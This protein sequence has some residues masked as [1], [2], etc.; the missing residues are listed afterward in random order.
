MKVK[1]IYDVLKLTRGHR[2]SV[3]YGADVLFGKLCKAVCIVQKH[4]AAVHNPLRS[5]VFER[6][7]K[8]LRCKNYHINVFVVIIDAAPFPSAAES[9]LDK[10]NADIAKP[11]R[12]F[13]AEPLFSIARG[14]YQVRVLKLVSGDGAS[15]RRAYCDNCADIFVLLGKAHKSV[16]YIFISVGHTIIL[17]LICQVVFISRCIQSISTSAM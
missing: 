8:L 4:I 11:L 3:G 5:A 1:I 15:H 6:A 13:A 16:F 9:R 2:R 17:H 7:F 14:N 12:V 10:G